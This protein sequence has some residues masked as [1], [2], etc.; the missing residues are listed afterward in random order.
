MSISLRSKISV[1]LALIIILSMS[2]AFFAT[3][4]SRARAASQTDWPMFGFDAQHTHYNPNESVLNPTNVSGLTLDWSYTTGDFI[5]NSSPAVSNGIAYIV[6]LDHKLYALNAITGAFIWSY[7][8]NISGHENISSPA[9]ANGIVYI[10]SDNSNLYA[11][12]AVTG[13]LKWS[14]TIGG[15]TGTDSSPAVSNGI[16]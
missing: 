12:D 15:G 8:I 5:Y 16:V 9:V 7:T 11:F 1:L 6:S 4:N 13:T 14:Q 2:L 3:A 10:G